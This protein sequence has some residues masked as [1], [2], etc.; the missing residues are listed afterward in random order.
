MTRLLRLDT[1]SLNR[2]KGMREMALQR[3]WEPKNKTDLFN[4]HALILSIQR[5]ESHEHPQSQASAQGDKPTRQKRPILHKLSRNIPCGSSLGPVEE[6]LPGTGQEA[7]HH[8]ENREG[9]RTGGDESRPKP[10][11]PGNCPACG[12]ACAHAAIE[13][14]GVPPVGAAQMG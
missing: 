8:Q 10:D 12:G 3:A 14:E 9:D 2:P 11:P 7:Q 13:G 6:N 5:H 4:L 1:L